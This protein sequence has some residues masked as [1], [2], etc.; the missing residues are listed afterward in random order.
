[1]KKIVGVIF[2]FLPAISMVTG[3]DI[4]FSLPEYAPLALN[5]GLAGANNAMEGAINYRNQWSS[6][7]EPYKT[8]VA[9]FYSRLPGRK[10]TQTN[11]FAVGLQ[12]MND[13]AGLPGVASN[14]ISLAVA[15]HVMISSAS[16]I[17]LGLNFG[18]VQRSIDQA[19]GQ[20]ASQYDGSA[21][22]PGSSSGEVFSNPSYGILDV[23]AGLVYTYQHKQ[24][25]L[26]KSMDR[27]LSAGL[28]VMHVNRP[29][30]SFIETGNDRLP[31]RYSAFANGEIAFGSTDVS[32]LPGFWYHRQGEFSQL[33]FGSSLRYKIVPETRY[34]GF[35]K[36]F[37]LTVGLFGRLKDALVA[38]LVVDYDRYAF[39][40]SFDFNSSGLNAYTGGRGAQEFFLRFSLSDVQQ[41]RAR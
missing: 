40:Y 17:G 37:S 11:N 6:L 21:F 35:I 13:K 25:T 24:S 34:T 15:D 14:S 31:L 23:G 4:H 9:S 1:M 22:N 5:P 30:N 10:K 29:N 38:R 16:K 3:Q 12:F 27:F 36:P 26:A 32:V 2:F 19:T 39:G 20:W 41:I 7:G 8:L 18:Y 33:M 28:S